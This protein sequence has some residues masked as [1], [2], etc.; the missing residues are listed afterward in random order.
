MLTN[1]VS[2]LE[3]PFFKIFRTYFYLS[4]YKV[5]SMNGLVKHLLLTE[6]KEPAYS[7]TITCILGLRM[8]NFMFSVR[9][10]VGKIRYTE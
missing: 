8:N 3:T 7:Q 6:K 1:Y 5:I 4:R 10:Q 9:I 2:I